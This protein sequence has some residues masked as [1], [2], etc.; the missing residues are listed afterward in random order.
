MR[1]A[2]GVAQPEPATPAG[3]DHAVGTPPAGEGAA[4]H[5]TR[6]VFISPISLVWA[7]MMPWAMV[8]NCGLLPRRA[9]PR[10]RARHPSSCVGKDR[11]R[12]PGI[13]D[14]EVAG[15]FGRETS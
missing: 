13:G 2:T 5:L 8:R 14:E 4:Y 1:V 12:S 7:A 15:V 6:Q 3:T 9:G 10:G 11:R